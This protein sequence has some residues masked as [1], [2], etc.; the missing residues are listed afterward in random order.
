MKILKTAQLK[1]IKFK[2]KL[3]IKT[4]H[5]TDWCWIFIL[6]MTFRNCLSDV[7]LVLEERGSDLERK[8]GIYLEN[9]E[10]CF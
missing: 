10:N 2:E 5:L 3:W 8:N 4:W 6:S 7:E 9:L 1:C